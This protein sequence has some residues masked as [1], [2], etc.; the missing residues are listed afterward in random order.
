MAGVAAGVHANRKKRGS[1]APGKSSSRTKITKIFNAISRPSGPLH[2]DRS[3]AFNDLF[4]FVFFVFFVSW[5]EQWPDL[6]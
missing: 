4:F 6:G 2:G 3:D 1:L 5:C